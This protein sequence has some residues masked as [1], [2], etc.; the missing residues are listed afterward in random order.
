MAT[1][2]IIDDDGADPGALRRSLEEAGHRVVEAAGEEALERTAAELARVC[3]ELREAI[4]ALRRM[5]ATDALT[6]LA[7]RRQLEET[8]ARELARV[9]RAAGLLCVLVA[10]IDRL[11]EI[12]ETHGHAAGDVVL[13]TVARALAGTV[14]AVDFTARLGGGSFAVLAPMTDCK[15]GV[16]LA[17]R[18]RDR[19]ATS[20][21]AVEGGELAVTLS[22]GVA[23]GT[24]RTRSFEALL[25]AA[26]QSLRRAKAAGRN[27]VAATIY[28]APEEVKPAP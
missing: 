7:N 24:P 13:A 15:G 28:V 8:G 14:R 16:E 12:N 3:G 2:L 4:E 27:R 1:V 9:Q 18:L 25:S 11:E 22:V 19:V 21:V 6:G 5:E 17:E 10:D 20:P 23:Q 26:E